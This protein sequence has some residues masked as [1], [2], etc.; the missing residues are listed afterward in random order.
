MK[1]SEIFVCLPNFSGGGAERVMTLV[2]HLLSSK[3]SYVPNKNLSDQNLPTIASTIPSQKQSF[4]NQ[5]WGLLHETKS[6]FIVTCVVLND[7]G[8][9]KSAVSESCE[10]V[11]LKIPS[12]RSAI[13]SLVKLFRQRKPKIVI[14]TLAY[15]NFVIVMALLVSR[16]E[17]KR[18]IIRE[19]NVPRSTLDTFPLRYVGPFLYRWLYNRSDIVICNSREISDQ[20]VALGVERSRLAL[21]PNPID[22]DFVRKQALE[23]INLPIFL[24]P[25][26]ALLISVGRLT[27]QKGMDRLI[28][29][30]AAMGVKANLLIIGQGPERGN[31]EYSIESNGLTGRAKIIDFQD[32]PFPY[33]SNADAILLGSR[34][35]GLPNV[36]LEAMALGK[37]VVATTHCGGLLDIKHLLDDQALV[38]AGTDEEYIKI[39]D[40][41]ANQ[42]GST[43]NAKKITHS[44]NQL[45][46]SK[47]PS[48]YTLESVMKKYEAAIFGR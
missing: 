45:A 7:D 21:I 47:L 27:K 44:G 41:V 15:F 39:L 32:N 34:W 2:A 12:A 23:S 14:S 29:W 31:L 3:S 8:P 5:K 37:Q 18:T 4:T 25:S 42:H 11:N 33:M 17:P 22:V 19:A 35:E 30:V 46:D 13:A 38:I 10:I 6:D 43:R 48:N 9:L 28:N 1:R 24:D 26:L 40:R 36:A 20:L 16:H